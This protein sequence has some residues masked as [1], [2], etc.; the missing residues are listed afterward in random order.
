MSD[1]CRRPRPASAARIGTLL[2][3]NGGL[4]LAAALLISWSGLGLV[5]SGYTT[6][7]VLLSAIEQRWALTPGIT[8]LMAVGV[9]AFVLV[10]FV[11][12]AVAG[13]LAKRLRVDEEG[14]SLDALCWSWRAVRRYLWMLLLPPLALLVQEV[15][16]IR[17]LAWV[18]VLPALAFC[19]FLNDR[20]LLAGSA[21]GWRLRWRWPGWI[22]LAGL[23]LL[24]LLDWAVEAL[25]MGSFRYL[26][27]QPGF[28]AA[29]LALPVALVVVLLAGAWNQAASNG[30]WLG[31]I[32]DRSGFWMTL[33]QALRRKRLSAYVALEFRVGALLLALMPW[34]LVF[35]VLS[36]YDL[37]NWEFALDAQGR[38]IPDA[39]SAML[40]ILADDAVLLLLPLALPLALA[41][42]RLWVLLDRDTPT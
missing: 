23:L 33:R 35:K 37:P 10:G 14:R 32:R 19:F 3:V 41:Y 2:G 38:E 6:A 29:W 34:V 17:G 13:A 36:I 39:L 21:E 1:P 5:E 18:L 12:G 30:L 11:L 31:G 24:S 27:G 28:H 8:G 26:Q 40:R 15:L 16:E 42:R 7:G 25:L 22:V 4:C 9:L 20:A